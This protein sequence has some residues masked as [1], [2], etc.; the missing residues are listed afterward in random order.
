M[1]KLKANGGKSVASYHAYIRTAKKDTQS[2][3]TKA[4][5]FY[6]T[7]VT[8]SQK[9]HQTYRTRETKMSIYV[10]S[11]DANELN[12]ENVSVLSLGKS[13]SYESQ[14]HSSILFSI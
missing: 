2:D 6:W 4:V 7:S 14:V 13:E 12:L 8:V 9:Q 10:R 1:I 5:N 11:V 3:G